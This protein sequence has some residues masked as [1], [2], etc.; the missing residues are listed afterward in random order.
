LKTSHAIKD[1]IGLL[2]RF[3]KLPVKLGTQLSLARRRRRTDLRG[4][5][6]ELPSAT[7]LQREVSS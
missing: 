6:G 5:L 1:G 3:E 7:L 4:Q 2:D